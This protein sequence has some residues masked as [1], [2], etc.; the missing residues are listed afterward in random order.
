[1]RAGRIVAA[2]VAAVAFSVALAGC[3]SAGRVLPPASTVAAGTP[4][5]EAALTQSPTPT[6][7][8]VE[9]CQDE[10]LTGTY[11]AKPQD[12]GAGQF[13]GDLTFTNIS[14]VDCSF[15]GWPGL[16]AFGSDGAQLGGAASREGEASTPVLLMANGGSGV[17]APARQP[18]RSLRLPRGDVV[19]GAC[20]VHL[21]RRR[22]GSR[23]ASRDPG[24]RRR[25]VDVAGWP[26]RGAVGSRRYAVAPVIP[27]VDSMTVF[28]FLSRASKNIDSGNSSSRTRSV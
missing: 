16:L 5:P 10:Q 18:A 20:L 23:R 28:I 22:G 25:D 3:S 6:G 26:A 14:A 12:S 17:A 27:T 1:M 8:A 15:D 4:T 11:T 21:G 19:A 13:Y 24:L 7:G 9:A 2:A